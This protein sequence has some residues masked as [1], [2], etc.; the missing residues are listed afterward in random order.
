MFTT[1]P[2]QLR[3]MAK[4]ALGYVPFIGWHLRWS[5]HLLVDRKKPGAA[6]FKRMQRLTTQG[7]S[8][9]GVSG[10]ITL[11]RRAREEVQRRCVSAG[12]RDG[13]AR[14]AAE[15]LGNRKVMPAG[16]L[17]TCPATVRLVVHDPILTAGL[18]RDDAR[19]LAERVR[20]VVA[21]PPEL[22]LGV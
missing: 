17:M 14:G 10:G 22:G 19:G 15:H 2:H 6:I 11:P 18:T 9:L 1:L 5:G 12:D 20:A 7:A 16:R 21:S 4:A 8:L 13:L 3:M